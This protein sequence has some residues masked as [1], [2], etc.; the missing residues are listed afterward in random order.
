MAGLEKVLYRWIRRAN[1]RREY[2]DLPPGSIEDRVGLLQ[3]TLGTDYLERI[4]VSDSTPVHFLDDEINPLRKWLLSAM[5]D[6]HIIQVLE[7]ASYLEEF[8]GDPAL[9]DKVEKLTR[10]SFWPIF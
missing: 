2:L 9:A 4:L 5:V 7:L 10:D 8:Q 3:R 6:Q 1:E